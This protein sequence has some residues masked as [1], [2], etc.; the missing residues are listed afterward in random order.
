MSITGAFWKG[1][2]IARRI[3]PIIDLPMPPCAR[4]VVNLPRSDRP[5]ETGIPAIE[6][7]ALLIV[8]V[9][10]GMGQRPA[11]AMCRRRFQPAMV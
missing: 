4:A 11:L 3:D 9:S 2:W 8:V 1:A 10:A 6:T 5:G 7:A